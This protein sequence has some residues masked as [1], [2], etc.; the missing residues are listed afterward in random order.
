MFF[1]Y[2]CSRIV[3]SKLRNNQII[4]VQ[5][6]KGRFFIVKNSD[7]QELLYTI[8]DFFWNNGNEVIIEDNFIDK[9]YY[10]N[11]LLKK[12]WIIT[13][14]SD[15]FLE[16]VNRIKVFGQPNHFIILN[17]SANGV[18]TNLIPFPHKVFSYKSLNK[19]Q[20]NLFFQVVCKI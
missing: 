8:A 18:Y 13:F 2:I 20:L 7:Y 14:N 16:T 17:F 3:W 15:N 1:K 4:I 6:M 10:N 11:F 5:F 9:S 19:S 12:P